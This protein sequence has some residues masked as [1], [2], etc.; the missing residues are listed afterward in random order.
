MNEQVLLKKGIKNDGSDA[1]CFDHF[2]ITS[3]YQQLLK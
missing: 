2:F 1:T 3:T